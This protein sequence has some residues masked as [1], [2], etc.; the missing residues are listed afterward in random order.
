MIIVPPIPIPP[1]VNDDTVEIGRFIAEMGHRIDGNSRC[2]NRCHHVTQWSLTHLV[3]SFD[4][5]HVCV[6]AT[7]V[8]SAR[9]NEVAEPVDGLWL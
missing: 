8:A 3:C 9:D 4:R 1:G 7:A 5:V 6:C 2:L